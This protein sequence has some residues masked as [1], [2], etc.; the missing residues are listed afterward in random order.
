[1]SSP[2]HT[3]NKGKDILILG[4]GPTQRW[5][6][7]TLT[8]EVKYAINFTQSRKIFVLCLH[9]NGSRKLCTVFR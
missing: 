4:K 8:A 1:M 6:H 3:D 5:D 2:M 7:M 9:Y